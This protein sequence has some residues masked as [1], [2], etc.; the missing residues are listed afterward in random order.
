MIKYTFN[1]TSFMNGSIEP[2]S[3]VSPHQIDTCPVYENVSGAGCQQ[4]DV[5]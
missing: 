1:K 4:E 5:D 2:N 3:V